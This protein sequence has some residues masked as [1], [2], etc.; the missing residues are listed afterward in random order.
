MAKKPVKK[1]DPNALYE[2]SVLRPVKTP[3]GL[4]LRPGQKVRLKPHMIDQLG[5]GVERA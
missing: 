2:V 4:T 3:G 5:E 1:N